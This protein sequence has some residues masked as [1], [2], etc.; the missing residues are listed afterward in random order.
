MKQI[1]PYIIIVFLVGWIVYD[2]VREDEVDIIS[3]E[4]VT[5][6]DSTVVDSL[7]K[8]IEYLE[9]INNPDTVEVRVEVPVPVETDGG[10]N[11][12]EPSYSDSLITAKW[13][14]TV[15]GTIV[16]EIEFEYF[17]KKRVVREDVTT[18]TET[19]YVTTTRT[20]TQRIR[21]K[22]HLSVGGFTGVVGLNDVSSVQ[23]GG[24]LKYTNSDRQSV[25]VNYD[26]LNQGVMVGFTIPLSIRN[27]F[28]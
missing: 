5:T 27:L 18:I 2:I 28:N 19:R 12:Y 13:G 7:N 1:I 20:I 24:T 22:G 16:E 6:I 25:Y 9:N 14:L 4:T 11:R 8:R 3:D 23:L 10:F 15:D 21:P 26:F 17:L